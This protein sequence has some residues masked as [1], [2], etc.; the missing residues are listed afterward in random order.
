MFKPKSIIFF[1]VVTCVKNNYMDD[2]KLFKGFNPDFLVD[3][4]IKQKVSFPS[5]QKKRKTELAPVKY[6]DKL[7]ID[8]L[9]YSVLVIRFKEISDFHRHKY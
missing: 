6:N 7:K 2:E 9:N 8:Y 3:D 5:L 4:K 1:S